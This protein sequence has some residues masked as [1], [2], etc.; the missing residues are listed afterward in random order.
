M[1]ILL[2]SAILLATATAACAQTP[3]APAAPPPPSFDVPSTP[4]TVYIARRNLKAGENVGLH[5]HAGEE[6]TQVISGDV[7]LTVDGKS[8]VYHGGQSFMVAR[9]AKH[10]AKAVT[11]AVLAVTYVLDKGAPL[12]TAVP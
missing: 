6:M 10:D 3:A 9:G 5:T 11:E 2:A 8:T 4:T 7:E 1:R 12:R